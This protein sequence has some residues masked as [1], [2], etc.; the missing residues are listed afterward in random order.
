V[1][2]ALYDLSFN[3]VG[4]YDL[5]RIIM[6]SIFLHCLTHVTLSHPRARG[7]SNPFV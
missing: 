2:Y 5:I 4:S 6:N 1:V 7:S 3:T